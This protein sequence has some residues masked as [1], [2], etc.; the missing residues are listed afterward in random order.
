MLSIA[1]QLNGTVS[2]VQAAASAAV[3]VL[4]GTPEGDALADALE[5]LMTKVQTPPERAPFSDAE[6]KCGKAMLRVRSAQI[7]VKDALRRGKYTDA[8]IKEAKCKVAKANLVLDYGP[9]TRQV[10]GSAMSVAMSAVDAEFEAF[11][12]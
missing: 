10:I 6:R 5:T 8:D 1:N 3:E 7:S 2:E 4:E 12:F 9:N 11:G